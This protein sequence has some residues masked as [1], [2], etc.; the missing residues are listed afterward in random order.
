MKTILI[1][2]ATGLFT[3]YVDAQQKSLQ[4]IVIDES[5]NSESIAETL[6]IDSVWSVHPVGFGLLTHNNRQYI[7][8]YNSNRNMVVGQRNLDDPEFE[9]HVLP[10]T[11]R[12]THGGT[13]TVLNWD[14]HN[15]VTINIDNKGYLHL[16]GNM[17]VH[18]LTYFRSTRPNDITSLE[19]IMEMVGSEEKRCTYPKFMKDRE[20]NLLFHYRDGGSGNGNEIYN[21]YNTE[22]QKWRRLLDVPLTDGQGQM[23]AY[24]S[25]PQLMK[26]NWYHVYWVWRDTP[27]CETNHDLS[28]MKSPDLVNW[29]NGYGEPVELP[30]TINNKSLIVDPVPPGGGIIN[31]AARL[32]LDEN[33]KPVFVYHK[34]DE[35]G[36]LQLYIAQ[37]KHKKWVSKKITDWDYRW[38][39]SGRGTIVFEVGL[40]GFISRPDGYYEIGYRHIKYGNGTLLLDKNFD[41]VGKVIKPQSSG[42]LFTKEGNFQG[43]E[44]R[45]ANDSGNSG[46][47]NIRYVLKWETLSQNRD[48][49]RSEPWPAPSNLY[50]YK[51]VR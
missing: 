47:K 46:E 48:K 12:K 25:Q 36:N 33:N 11:S 22:T 23:N 41:V 2:V 40:N 18:P 49:P 34:Y 50:L 10:P 42:E 44:V 37:L 32:C 17:H 16:A 20:G 28:Y 31:L 27:D 24:Q 39:F 8:Y 26:D 5:A 35:E 19:Q 45:T 6:V 38:E 7:A 4:P 1:L 15:Y 14:S 9:L 29:Y 30:A 51:L 3:L 21:I 43:L 13:S